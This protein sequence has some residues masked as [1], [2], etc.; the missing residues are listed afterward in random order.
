M[1]Y[2]V[3]F[4]E[5]WYL[6]AGPAISL[7]IIW[8]EITIAPRNAYVSGYLALAGNLAMFAL[9]AWMTSP[10]IIGPGPGIIV[11]SV[12]ATHRK[13]IATWLVAV[14]ALVA[15]LVPWLLE[16]LG[17]SASRTSIV[18]GDIIIHTAARELGTSATLI[19]LVIYLVSIVSLAALLSRL[20]DNERRAARQKVELQSWQLKQL[21]PR[22]A[23]GRVVYDNP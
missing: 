13:M 19:A 17:A 14:L 5:P 2:W 8:V 7:F 10:I 21:V 12:L 1:L 9:F 22:S 23:S 18:G 6:I 11:V 20:Q 16:L 3:G 15:T 4:R